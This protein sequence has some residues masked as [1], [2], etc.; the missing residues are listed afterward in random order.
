LGYYSFV[1]L[2]ILDDHQVVADSLKN[3]LLETLTDAEFVYCGG[4]IDEICDASVKLLP[5]L[6]IVD[7]DLGDNKTPAMVVSKV[8]ETGVRVLVL[9]ASTDSADVLS[10]LSAGA[11]GYITKHASSEELTEAIVDAVEKNE[12][13]ISPYVAGAL[14]EISQDSVRLSAQEKRALVLYASGL[15]LEAV[16]RRMNIA[17]S[18]AKQYIDRVK[19][20]YQ[21]QGRAVHTKTDMYRAAKDAG[22]LK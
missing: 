1:K 3:H 4:N 10:A 11:I 7:L 9:S 19:S 15:K 22:Y 2:A 6:V 16:A 18:T 5:D 14:A 13:K 8:A 17:P 12:V 20:K 21:Q